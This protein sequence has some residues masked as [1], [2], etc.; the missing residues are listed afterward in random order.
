MITNPTTVQHDARGDVREKRIVCGQLLVCRSSYVTDDV[1]VP[2]LILEETTGHHV[3]H[4]SLC[5]SEAVSA[6]G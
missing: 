3:R 4:H 1:E 5:V 6:T 2:V